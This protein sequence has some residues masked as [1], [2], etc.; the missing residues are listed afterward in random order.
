MVDLVCYRCGETNP[1]GNGKRCPCGEPLW[2]DTDATGFSWEDA[3]EANSM[4]RYDRLLPVESP[5][6]IAGAAGGTPLVRAG[7]LDAYAGCRV[8][9]KDETAHPTGSFKDRGSALGVAYVL[10]EGRET[11][12]TVSHGN[13][14]MSTA[15]HAAAFD[16]R[17]VVLVP[18][19]I[20]AE[21]L[22]IIAQYGPELV[23][24]EGDYGRL[25]EETLDLGPEFGIAFV[26][27]DT[28]LRV[29]GQKT[30]GL[31]ICE[32]FAPG[33]PDAIVLP[34]S[35]GGH[36][37]GIWKALCELETAGVID[38]VPPLYLVQAA[39]CA[40][41]AEAYDAGTEAVSRIH[42]EETIAY[43]IANP[44]PPSGTRALAA[45]RETEGAV[46]AVTDG[47]IREAK[48]RL[49]DR[50]GLCVEPASATALAGA[51]KLVHEG[52]IDA[53]DDVVL[54]ATG[55]G[56]K[57]R[58]GSPDVSP[59]RVSLDGLTGALSAVADDR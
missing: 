4:W 46:L 57:E 1:P 36:A 49:A 11:V 13:M 18:A 56:F 44:D 45:A 29:E 8:H 9:I 43:S 40:P 22:S 5:G 6:G 3:T 54:V 24:V 55:T 35:S 39:A 12:G 27:S 59:T 14:A 25:Y 16:R 2:I 51:R 20:P 23:Q 17:C 19:D 15:A 34:V 26:N 53:P 30:T 52:E 58:G 7:R 37:S 50:A 42:P 10:R 33:V 32:A 47:A 31:E 38:S 41:I 21:R 48:S 28:P